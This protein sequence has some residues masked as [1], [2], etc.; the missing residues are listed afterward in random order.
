MAVRVILKNPKVLAALLIIGLVIAMIMVILNLGMA[1]GSG[2]MGAVVASSY[3]AEDED[4]TNASVLFSGLE[5]DFIEEIENIPLNHPGFDEYRIEIDFNLITHNPFEL[6]AYLTSVHLDFSGADIAAHLQSL[7]A[8]QYQLVFTPTIEIRFTEDD[9]GNPVPYDWH[10]LTV[11]MI[12]RPFSEVIQERMTEEQQF[13]F[14]VLMQSLGNR[15]QIASPFDFNWLP[16]VSSHFGYRIHPILGGRQF[17]AGIDIGL[18]TGTPIRAGHDGIVT[19]AGYNTGGFGNL[20][21]IDSG[22]GLVTKYA[23]CDTLLV[24]TGQEVSAGDVIATVGST[25]QSTGPHL[26]MEVLING[27]HFNP[28]F[29]VSPQP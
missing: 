9:Y 24:T 18:P 16:H 25:G 26:H 27:Q 20:V 11:T 3:L 15:Q 8:E 23:H 19:F 5:L 7:F 29:L 13:H 1:I 6:M 17:H 28:A 21:I 12:S 14:T 2:G 22:D 4:I 10:V